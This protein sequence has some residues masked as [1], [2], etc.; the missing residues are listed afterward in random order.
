MPIE[1]GTD[2]LANGFAE[3]IFR[4]PRNQCSKFFIARYQSSNG[5]ATLTESVPMS[6]LSSPHASQVKGV[7]P[8]FIKIYGQA[9]AA[10]SQGLGE[11]AGVGYR[12]AL[13]FLL[14]D[15]LIA[16]TD[17]EDTKTEIRASFLGRCIDKFVKNENVRVVSK[18]AVWLGNDETHYV[19]LWE[20]KDVKDLK[21]LIALTESWIE[22]ELRTVEWQ[23][24]MPD[25]H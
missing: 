11:I 14:K 2:F 6:P 8:S 1:T 17:N 5:F 16:S 3:S 7:S 4:C 20:G 23:K 9:E 13:E 24:E 18:R 21:S 19:R 10:E 25:G 15:Y 12:R 22:L